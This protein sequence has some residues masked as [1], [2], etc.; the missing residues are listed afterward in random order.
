M[1]GFIVQTAVQVI[2][3]A[4]VGA[5]VGY[6]VAAIID[7]LSEKFT[8]VW[9]ELVDS[10]KAIWGYVTEET[11]HFLALV[12]QWLENNWDEIAAYLRQELDYGKRCLVGVFEQDNEIFI[13]FADLDSRIEKPSPIVS[14][15]PVQENV[16]IPPMREDP[17]MAVVGT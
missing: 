7:A 16:K 13:G 14:I 4:V 3:G 8:Q 17:I 2:A 1:W 15:S 10:A 5:A 6:G 9:Q 11:Q 12:S